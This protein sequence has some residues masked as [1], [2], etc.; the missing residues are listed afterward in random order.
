MT[1]IERTRAK[2]DALNTLGLGLY[3]TPTD[4]RLAWRQ[5]AFRK[6]PDCN[7]QTQSDF[8]AA[9]AAYDFLRS[10]MGAALPEAS[11]QAGGAAAH[12]VRRPEITPRTE[13]LAPEA[14][15]H[16]RALLAAPAERVD[17]TEAGQRPA[18]AA[19]DHVPTFV[20]RRGRNLTY[21]VATPLARGRNRVALP[22][23]LLEGTRRLD[24]T[25]VS[26]LSAEAG[27]GEY[28]LPEFG[29]ARLIRGARSV[30]I[31]FGGE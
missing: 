16:C 19:A 17:D 12:R 8:T 9:K 29:S 14:I 11:S 27:P 1:P 13:A 23:A 22:T 18:K 6:H 21:V 30:T 4:V 28:R 10:E 26:F 20:E 3:A 2:A 24:P 5:I 15:A 31:R 7:D 25:I